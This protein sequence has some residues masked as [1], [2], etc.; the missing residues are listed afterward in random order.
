M[1]ESYAIQP[2][3]L[4]EVCVLVGIVSVPLGVIRSEVH[5]LSKII[6]NVI[7]EHIFNSNLILVIYSNHLKI[8]DNTFS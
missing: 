7:K 8:L 2:T 6:T 4:P 5:F 1:G 3:A